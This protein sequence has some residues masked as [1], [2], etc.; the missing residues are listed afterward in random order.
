MSNVCYSPLGRLLDWSRWRRPLAMSLVMANHTQIW[1]YNV[2]FKC[3][4]QR[5][6]LS[7]G[8][9][10]TPERTSL[11]VDSYLSY[12][13]RRSSV[14]RFFLTSLICS[15]CCMNS[16]LISFS[17]SAQKAAGEAR[18]EHTVHTHTLTSTETRSSECCCS[19]LGLAIYFWGIF[20]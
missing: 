18:R 1:W 19:K 12:S 17:C 9:T 6:S 7:I 10:S 8:Q 5:F 20:V 16:W 15:S 2:T 3:R 14:V 13:S 11:V 4:I